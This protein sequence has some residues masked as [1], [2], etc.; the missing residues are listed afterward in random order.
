M[1]LPARYVLVLFVPTPPTFSGLAHRFSLVIDGLCRVTAARIATDRSAGPL[2]ILIVGRLRR[3]AARFA[4][5]AA[6][7]QAGPLPPPRR[8]AARPGPPRNNRQR[9]LPE[10]FA[11]LIRLVPETAGYGGQVHALLS[12]PEMAAL[13][14]AVPQAGRILR[15]LCRM[16]AVRPD[17]PMLRPPPKRARTAA[18]PGPEP[19][20]TDP[21]GP[22]PAALVWRRWRGVRMPVLLRTTAPG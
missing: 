8:R 16:M 2:L 3:L 17:A 14:E 10:S 11:W 13:L 12:D 19:A 15:P 7:A 22:E 18:P 9:P 6:R 4:A 20:R 5:L 21:P 1:T